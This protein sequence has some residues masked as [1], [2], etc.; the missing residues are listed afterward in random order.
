MFAE[1]RKLAIIKRVN[2]N[3]SVSLAELL[4]A[5]HVSETTIRRDLTE[6]ENAGELIRT[7]GGAIPIKTEPITSIRHDKQEGY[8]KEK[9]SIA[10]VVASMVKP[11]DTILL[12]AGTTTAQIA[13]ALSGKPVTLI[14]NSAV[15]AS[16]FLVSKAQMEIHSTGG[17]F[18][19]AT[20]A[21]VGSAAENYLRQIRPDRAFIS[22]GGIS[23]ESGA[24]TAHLL[25]ASI[26]KTMMSVSKQVFLVADHSKF[27]KEYFS[28]IDRADAFDGIITDKWIS[29]Q[30]VAQ[31]NKADIPIIKETQ[32]D[33]AE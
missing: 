23:I 24:T 7:H 32:M 26:K 21:F 33:E 22:A 19:S 13:R 10:N 27:G 5:F 3:A 2:T 6:L 9:K 17:L 18:R 8:F 1:Q 14:T 30:M 11:G 12:D 29:N 25:E 4:S 15:I 28:V 31:F 20:N 16:K